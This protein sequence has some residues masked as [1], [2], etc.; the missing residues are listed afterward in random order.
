MTMSPSAPK[1][2]SFGC[3]LNSFESEIMRNHAIDAGLA[4]TVIVNSCAVT[5]E[6]ERQTR[7]AIR[8][9][10]REHPNGRII[11]TG[12]AAQIDADRY[13]AMAE[14]DH[15]LGNQEKLDPARYRNLSRDPSAGRV[16]VG[17]IQTADDTPPALIDGLEGRTRAF[18]QVQNGCN[19]RC[20]FCIIPFGR[21]RARSVP[22]PAIIA[23][24]E[25]LVVLG[26]HEVVVSGVDIASYGTDLPDRPRLG[27]MLRQVLDAVPGLARLRLSSLDPASLDADLLDL[28][29]R[30]PRLMPHFHLSIQ[31]GDDLIL[32]RMKRRHNRD[33]VI[34]CVAALR[35]RR[36]DIVFGADL[37]AGFPTEDNA[38]FAN[39]MRLVEA[40]DI[41]YLH[42][43]PY[44]PRTGTPA[45]RMPQ[46]PI[47]LRRARAGELRALG[48]RQRDRYLAAQTGKR[49]EILAETK[50]R[51][52]TA[53]FA[54]VDLVAAQHFAP[55]SLAT[56]RATGVRDG[57]LIGELA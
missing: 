16:D 40:C 4:D 41:T 12:C 57:A 7:Q 42:V 39:T 49:L 43:F 30:E 6:A 17:D 44:S 36:P 55:G 22:A 13:A 27:T 46:L 52:R 8:R 29:A 34:A 14:V 51:G 3:R 23:Q 18:I 21:G 38:M 2:L 35:A 1:V 45:A 33:D 28:V 54:T 5:H 56:I 53:H 9:A 25:R 48:D 32:K 24:L 26:C 11:V 31:A 15:V 47:E 20:T 19:H 10:R 50:A 37:I